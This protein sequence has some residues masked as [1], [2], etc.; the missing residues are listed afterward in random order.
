MKVRKILNKYDLPSI[1]DLLSDPPT[2]PEWKAS[3]N[4]AVRTYWN[5]E[6][7]SDAKTKTSLKHLNI[8]KIQ[9][10]KPH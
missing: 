2:K 10:G 9:I 1:F 8:C 5:A 4:D 6:L 7:T 3:V